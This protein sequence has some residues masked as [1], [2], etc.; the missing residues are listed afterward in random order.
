MWLVSTMLEVAT[1]CKA[2]STSPEDGLLLG[3][4]AQ[5]KITIVHVS[6]NTLY[7]LDTVNMHD[8]QNIKIL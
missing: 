7:Y 6:W 5:R 4:N 8:I 2:H 3:R 1:K